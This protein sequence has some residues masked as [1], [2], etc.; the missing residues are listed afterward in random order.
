MMG[1]Q[2]ISTRRHCEPSGLAFGEPKDKLR[3]AISAEQ[4]V[5]RDWFGALS[6]A[7]Q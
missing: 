2:S 7:S 4:R 1:I 5:A 3:E 6:R